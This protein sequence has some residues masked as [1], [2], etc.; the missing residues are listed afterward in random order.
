MADVARDDLDALM[1]YD[2]FTPTVLFL[3]E[4]FGFCAPGESGPLVQSGALGLGCRYPGNTDGGHLSNSYMQGWALNVE[5]VRQ[6]RGTCGERQ[7]EGARICA[8]PLSPPPSSTGWTR[9]DRLRQAASGH[10]HADAAVLGRGTG[11]TARGAALPGVLGTPLPPPPRPAM[12]AGP[13]RWI[14]CK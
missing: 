13:P 3:L 10:H 9:H 5:A 7:V 4:G 8:P 1:I 2:N 11:R 14:G 12:P 6:L